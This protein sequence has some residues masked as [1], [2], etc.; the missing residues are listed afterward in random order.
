ME[1]KDVLRLTRARVVAL[2]LLALLAALLVGAQVGSR[3]TQYSAQAL[4]FLPSED[5]TLTT[6]SVDPVAAS[7][8]S[9]IHLPEVFTAASRSSSVPAGV[10]AAGLSVF[11]E[12]GDP[13][14][15]VTMTA[16][17]S[18]DASAGAGAMARAAL[19]SVAMR[20]YQTAQA[21]ALEAQQQLANADERLTTLVRALEVVDLEATL[22]GL[23]EQLAAAQAGN[24]PSRVA[25]LRNQINRLVAE[26][27]RFLGLTAARAAAQDAVTRNGVRLSAVEAQIAYARSPQSVL[28]GGA[29]PLSKRTTI[30]RGALGAFVVAWLVGLLLQVALQARRLRRGGRRRSSQTSDDLVEQA[31]TRSRVL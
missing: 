19:E 22:T 17:S 4:V 20:Q 28:L 16:S 14:V 9:A 31:A 27:P 7:F 11:R 10:L 1:V 8:V 2:T 13:T 6:F 29:A 25:S 24:Q 26:R 12:P 30:I 3:P 15:Q 18:R 5:G 21:G 23:S